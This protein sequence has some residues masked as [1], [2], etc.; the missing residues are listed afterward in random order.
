MN[1]KKP[2]RLTEHA[3][4]KAKILENHGFQISEEF[5]KIAIYDPDRIESSYKG[6]RVAQ[7]VMSESHVLRVIFE[8]YP[9]EIVV[10]TL[11]PGRRESYE[12]S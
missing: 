11:Y 10:I 9:E 6:R 3:E 2:I 7:K 12:K 1:K 4:L 5:V 8:E